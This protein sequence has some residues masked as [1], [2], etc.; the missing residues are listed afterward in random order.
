MALSLASLLPAA[1]S[2][3]A[4]GALSL[5]AAHTLGAASLQEVV[6]RPNVT[7]SFTGPPADYSFTYSASFTEAPEDVT[8]TAL[9]AIA[10][11]LQ[12]LAAGARGVV[13]DLVRV[14]QAHD[15]EV[16]AAEAATRARLDAHRA[17]YEASVRATEAELLE[18]MKL[19]DARAKTGTQRVLGTALAEF[20]ARL[21]SFVDAVAGT[22]ARHSMPPLRTARDRCRDAGRF[23]R[24]RGRGARVC[25]EHGADHRE[26]RHR[27]LDGGARSGTG[28]G[29]IPCVSCSAVARARGARGSCAGNHVPNAV[30]VANSRSSTSGPR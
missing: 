5:A 30:C 25:H 12:S 28:A 6:L 17:T 10:Y 14:R 16:R 23:A 9:R 4:V 3:E 8:R 20:V 22:A 2:A 7:L 15:A 13:H 21:V 26:R 11:E 1:L 18:E 27:H 24:D 29:G 19:A